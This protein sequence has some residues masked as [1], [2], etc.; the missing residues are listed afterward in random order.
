M[1]HSKL[2]LQ[3]L[4]RFIICFQVY[5]EQV[6]SLFKECMRA[7]Q[8][9]SGFEQTVRAEFKR[10]SALPRSHLVKQKLHLYHFHPQ[11][12]HSEDWVC[13]EEWTK[14][15]GD[16]EGSQGLGN[17][18]VGLLLSSFFSYIV[19]PKKLL[20]ECCWSQCVPVQSPVA[21]TH[22]AWKMYF[23]LFLVKTKQDQALPGH[24]DG[25]HSTQFW[26]WFLA[27]PAALYL[28]W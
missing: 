15:V 7:A 24:F 2:Q 11:V 14:E 1:K 17:G 9:K 4:S 5:P 16:D 20:I 8:Q 21:G 18:Q 26:L 25:P 22:R 10:N 3:V 12:W 6:L 28:P 23:C 19:S 13:H 27:T